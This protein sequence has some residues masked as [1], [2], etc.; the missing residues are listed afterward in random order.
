MSK[1]QGTLRAMARVQANT[2]RS[3]RCREPSAMARGSGR[4]AQKKGGERERS[5]GW[6]FTAAPGGAHRQEEAAA[7]G[8]SA[9]AR[10]AR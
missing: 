5:R 2:P 8:R 9:A 3:T 7:E 6:D 10:T 1:D 4:R